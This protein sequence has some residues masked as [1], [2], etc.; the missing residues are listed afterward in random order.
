MGMPYAA[1]CAKPICS[2]VVFS[3]SPAA[4]ALV[5]DPTSVPS[6]PIEA[7]KAMPII[8][9]PGRPSLSPSATPPASS[10]ALAIGTMIKVVEVL[11]I[12]SDSVA[13][14][15]MK[16]SSNCA[17][18]WPERLTM[19]SASRLC[20]PTR[21]IASARNAPPRIRNRMGE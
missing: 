1:H 6:P 18:V 17:D 7:A 13:V 4:I 19:A 21:S 8:S 11:E 2:P 3:S 15:I 20:S 12:S 14:A 16:A 5:G 10:T 9:A